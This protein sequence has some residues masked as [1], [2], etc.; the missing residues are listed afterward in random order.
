[1]LS[2][3]HA[4]SGGRSL[5]CTLGAGSVQD[6]PT[7]MEKT[8]CLPAQTLMLS[9]WS[10]TSQPGGLTPGAGEVF[11]GGHPVRCRVSDNTPGRNL[12]D[13]RTPAPGRQKYMLTLPNVR[14]SRPWLGTQAL[15]NVVFA[16]TLLRAVNFPG[17]V[18]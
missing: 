2:S 9:L 17:V 11:A 13:A 7:T 10:S 15:G 12:L 4:A 6:P 18:F 14:Q 1:M 8:V 16:G 5:V 3:A